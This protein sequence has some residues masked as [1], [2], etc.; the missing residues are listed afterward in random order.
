MKSPLMFLLSLPLLL[1]ACSGKD[2][3]TIS[4]SGTLEATEITVGVLV[5]G[6]IDT[7]MVDEG[8]LVRAGDT[9]LI[10]DPT[11]TW[12]QLRQAEAANVAAMAQYRMALAGGRKEDIVQAEA[13]FKNAETDLKRM[14]ELW[15]RKSIPEKQYEDAT[16]RFTFAQ[17]QLEKLRRGLRPEEI[18]MVRAQ[19]D[20]AAIR[21]AALRTKLRD[22]YIVAPAN[23]TLLKRF[24]E[25][26]EVVMPG[27]S[28]ATIADLSAMHVT[29]YVPQIELSN[30]KLGQPASV[31][32]DAFPERTFPG[33]VMHIASTA[34]FTPKN[35]QT[36]D[37]RTKLV[38]AVKVKVMNPDGIL[39]AG[40]PADVVLQTDKP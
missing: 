7:V 20:Q 39:K 33:S 11:D 24:V 31:S 29:I 27:M 23:G 37:E 2:N 18:E 10:V 32:V 15:A 1:T 19:S 35:I 16:T 28:V 26:G 12:L 30:I 4:A 34:E 25:R 38:F 6:R 40:I 22:H 14:E 9:L 3:G 13:N 17:Q 36:K 21:V 8:R 5:G